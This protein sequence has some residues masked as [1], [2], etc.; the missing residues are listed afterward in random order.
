[1]KLPSASLGGTRPS[2]S[3]VATTNP[4]VVGCRVGGTG[5]EELPPASRAW[6]G[7]AL[8]TTRG[9]GSG[10]VEGRERGPHPA[11]ARSGKSMI[12]ARERDVLAAGAANRRLS[13]HDNRAAIL[14]ADCH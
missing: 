10:A 11:A 2:G 12:R 1:M 14:P 3:S 5:R 6:T 8:S 4:A 9:G 13:P 7:A